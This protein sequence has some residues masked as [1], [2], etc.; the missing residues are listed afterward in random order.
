[1]DLDSGGPPL[2]WP[3]YNRFKEIRALMRNQW[4]HGMSDT[5]RP[6]NDTSLWEHVYSVSSVSKVVHIKRLITGQFDPYGPK[7]FHLWG[8]GFDSLGYLSSGHKIGDITAR[9]EVIQAIF[10]RATQFIEFHAPLGNPIYRDET[11]AFFLTADVS[12]TTY[13]ELER[14]IDKI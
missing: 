11:C 8:L 1:L 13:Q 9:R 14:E 4:E 6:D 3:D 7:V 12:D 5:T 10:N 2:S